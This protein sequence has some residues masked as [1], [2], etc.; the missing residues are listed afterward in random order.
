MA[1]KK[2]TPELPEAVRA[3][4]AERAA[5]FMPVVEPIAVEAPEIEEQ[6]LELSPKEILEECAREP[7][8]DIGNARRLLTRFGD[9][10][11]SVTRVGFF[12]YD[13]QKWVE[14]ES[15]AVVRRLAHITAEFIDEEAILLDCPPEEQADIEAGR[16]ALEEMRAMGKPPAV[17]SQI[18]DERMAELDELIEDGKDAEVEKVKLGPAK[19]DWDDGLFDLLR[20]VKERI[21]LGKEA[22][23]QKKKMVDATSA[24]TDADYVKYAELEASVERMDVAQ[25]ARD[26]RIS[27]RHTFA[28]SSAGT[29]RINNMLEEVRPYCS[30]KVDELN[31]ETHAVNTRSGTLRFFTVQHEGKRVW[32][33]RMDPHRAI[34]RISKMAEVAFDPKAVCPQFERF[35]TFMHPNP[36]IRSF[37]QRF[38]GYSL[39]GITSEQILLFFYGAGNNGKSTLLKIITDILADYAV[40]MSIDSFAGEGKRG[41]AEATP[42]LARLPSARLVV[43]SEPEEGVKLKD[44]LIKLLTGGTKIPARRLHEDFFEFLPAFKMVIDGNHKPVIRDNSDGTWRRV[45]LVHFAIQIT[46]EQIDR[47]LPARLMTESAGIFAWMVRGALDYL[48]EG[49][50]IPQAVELATAAYREESDPVGAFIRNACLVTGEDKDWATPEELFNAYLVYAKRE[51][52]FLFNGNTFSKRVVEQTMKAWEG[53][54]GH[55]HQFTRKRNNGSRYCGILIRDEYRRGRQDGPPDDDDMPPVP[56]YDEE[57]NP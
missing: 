12:G 45:K 48:N 38:F 25:R 8:T 55:M 33:L 51:G 20:G 34:D 52:L 56:N 53:P 9:S 21:K 29:N 30:V 13:G 57:F 46:K 49:L 47:G 36:D 5:G 3:K 32:R 16:L 26:G 15:G 43:A 6:R 37:L 31:R 41:G 50:R 1:D 23:R 2:K 14:D 24:W 11:M 7:E 39:L 18:D 28:K 40:T 4:I 10:I 54:D 42:D 44:A 17:S 35:L 19:A 22:E 27:T